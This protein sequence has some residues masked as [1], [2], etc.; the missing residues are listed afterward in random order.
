LRSNCA[1]RKF[2]TAALS[3]LAGTLRVLDAHL[4]GNRVVRDD[5]ALANRKAALA[6]THVAPMIGNPPADGEPKASP[7]QDRGI[8]GRP[9]PDKGEQ[10]GGMRFSRTYAS[11][12]SIQRSGSGA[13]L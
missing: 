1:L 6:R 9:P 7:R 3:G 11:W 13:A 12:I 8:A 4:H 10:T 2:L 5:V